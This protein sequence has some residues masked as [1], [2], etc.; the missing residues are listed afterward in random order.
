MPQESGMVD[1]GKRIVHLKGNPREIGI[2]RGRILGSRLEENINRYI[3]GVPEDPQDLDEVRLRAEAMPTLRRLPVRFQEELEGLAEGAGTS[4][5]RVAEWI[6]VE[7][8]V[9]DSCSG[10]IV[11]INGH[12]WVGRNNDFRVPDLWGYVTIREV[13]DRIPTISLGME[14]D[15]F[16]V[17]GMNQER[18]W[19]HAQALPNSDA[20]RTNK[21]HFPGYVVVTEAL[22]TCSSIRDIEMLLTSIDRDESVMLFVIDGKTDE[23]AIFECTST[24]YNRRKPVGG[25]LIGT[26]HGRG[27]KPADISDSSLLRFCRLTELLSTGGCREIRAPEDLTAMLADSKVEQRNGKYVTVESAVACPAQKSIWYTLGG[28]PA[29]SRGNWTRIRWPWA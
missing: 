26:N 7:E 6:A 9:P 27:T 16:T 2:T 5:Q 14:G 1:A 20:P 28:Y 13:T 23:C 25:R 17:T 3:L 21:A 19:I 4:L 24:E 18:L 10:F 12:A 22:E 15:V 11:T 29:A 8:C